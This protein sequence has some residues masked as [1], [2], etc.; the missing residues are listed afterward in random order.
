MNQL[1]AICKNAV[2]HV[3]RS[4]IQA[5]LSTTLKQTRKPNP[6]LIQRPQRALFC[7]KLD[8]S[9]CYARYSCGNNC[10]VVI[11][12][13]QD[14]KFLKRILLPIYGNSS[15]GTTS[16]LGKRTVTSERSRSETRRCSVYSCSHL[17]PA[18]R[19]WCIVCHQSS[20]LLSSLCDSLSQCDRCTQCHPV[21]PRREADSSSQWSQL[22]LTVVVR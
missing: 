17:E 13:V 5:K 18:W 15:P 8:N 9:C 1:I 11:K 6:K 19:S 7:L 16:F 4:R 21:G 14:C 22:I 12:L 3:K 20:P 10:N 2:E